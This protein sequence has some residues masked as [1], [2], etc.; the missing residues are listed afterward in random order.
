MYV[1]QRISDDSFATLPGKFYSHR[2]VN[3]FTFPNKELAEKRKDPQTERV[4]CLA[5]MIHFAPVKVR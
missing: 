2:I 1:L 3:A 4:I 5:S